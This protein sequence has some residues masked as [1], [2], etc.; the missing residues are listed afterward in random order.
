MRV[1]NGKKRRVSDTCG[2][3]TSAECQT[4]S[5][6]KLHG[7]HVVFYGKSIV[8]VQ[9]TTV[10][11][12]SYSELLAIIQADILTNTIKWTE[13][14]RQV[15]LWELQWGRWIYI[16]SISC[17]VMKWWGF[18]FWQL[19]LVRNLS[20]QNVG[21]TSFLP[22]EVV[23]EENLHVY[24]NWYCVHRHRERSGKGTKRLLFYHI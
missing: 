23:K 16:V 24:S 15:G 8:C 6:H 1:G 17:V 19:R 9:C 18:S 11:L 20:S 12:I 10:P 7:S 22:S 2:I 13:S 21:K 5:S 3:C 4:L 14:L